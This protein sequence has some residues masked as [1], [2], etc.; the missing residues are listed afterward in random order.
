[1]KIFIDSVIPLESG[2]SSGKA[3]ATAAAILSMHA[4]NFH[5]KVDK[6]KF[7]NYLKEGLKFIQN[8]NYQE[9]SSENSKTFNDKNFEGYSFVI[10]N[11]LTPASHFAGLNTRY[12]KR[13]LELRIATILLSIEYDK[14]HSIIHPQSCP[15][16]TLIEFQKSNNFSFEEM[17]DF[18]NSKLRK[19]GYSKSQVEE[20]L[21]SDDV[22]IDLN[23][24]QY[25][26][27]VW[28][29]NYKFFIHERAIHVITEAQRVQEFLEQTTFLPEKF[30]KLMDESQKSLKEN[31]D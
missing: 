28:Q 16:K 18:I 23:D 29:N 21:N 1:M 22:V 12:N 15:H 8:K 27:E 7:S 30:G 19:G 2:L 9:I 31:F 4:N 26:Y 11:S 14:N 6:I 25:I 10:A 13:V 24:T 5:S 20:A 17:I 3:L